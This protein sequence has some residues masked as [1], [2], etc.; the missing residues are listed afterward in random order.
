MEGGAWLDREELLAACARIQCPVLV[1]QGTA[2]AIVGPA[3][4]PAIAAAIRS[5]FCCRPR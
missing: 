4:G 5:L 1:V 2:D 3:R